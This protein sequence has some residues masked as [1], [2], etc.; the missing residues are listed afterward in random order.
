MR[1]ILTAL[2]A[3]LLAAAPALADEAWTSGYGPIIWEADIGETAVLRL[4]ETGSGS[5]IHFLVPGLARDVS[6]GRGTYQG[7]WIA[8]QGEVPCLTD[9]VD[10]LTGAKSPYWGSFTLTFLRTEYPSDWAGAFGNC[11][12]AQ[13]D[14]LV[15]IDN[16][17][18]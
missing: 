8:S 1:P 10:P 14:P 12:D 15:G 17:A 9:M 11:F 2:A 4:D 3:T 6:G 7:L 13:T 16:S 5:V 18:Q